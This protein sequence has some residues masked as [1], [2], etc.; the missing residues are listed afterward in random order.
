M[1]D[2][3]DCG[4]VIEVPPG[5]SLWGRVV[6]KGVGNSPLQVFCCPRLESIPY[7]TSPLFS[8]QMALCHTLGTDN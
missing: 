3:T 4:E 6:G 2:E 8:N 1:V 5:V 7:H